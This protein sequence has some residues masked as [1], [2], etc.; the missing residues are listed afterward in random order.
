MSKRAVIVVGTHGAGKSRTI[1]ENFKTL[2]NMTVKQRKFE[3]GWVHSQTLEEKGLTSVDDY[4][5]EIEM[6]QFLV[7]AARPEKEKGSL[8]EA[9]RSRL[10]SEGY[11]VSVVFVSLMSTPDYYRKKGQE[12]FDALF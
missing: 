7:F 4:M 6:R 3:N 2:N 5:D 12:I 11:F 1:N 8:Q 10:K 9:L